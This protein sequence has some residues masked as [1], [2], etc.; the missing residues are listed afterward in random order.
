MLMNSLCVVKTC[1]GFSSTVSKISKPIIF[2][3][4]KNA[5]AWLEVASPIASFTVDLKTRIASANIV[6]Y[7]LERVKTGASEVE[8][9]FDDEEGYFSTPKTSCLCFCLHCSEQTGCIVSSQYIKAGFRQQMHHPNWPTSNPSSFFSFISGY[10]KSL[11]P[12]ETGLRGTLA[13]Y[14][15]KARDWTLT[16]SLRAVCTSSLAC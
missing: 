12:E 9:G 15:F 16:S 6:S 5:L 14:S 13:I 4:M 3:F 8:A 1:F 10:L 7:S 11:R 2:V